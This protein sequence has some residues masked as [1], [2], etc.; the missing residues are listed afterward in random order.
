MPLPR[1]AAVLRK[2]LRVI[3]IASQPPSDL[4]DSIDAF[5]SA[6]SSSSHGVMQSIFAPAFIKKVR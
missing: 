5:Y 4:V 1:A 6:A 3:D 2:L